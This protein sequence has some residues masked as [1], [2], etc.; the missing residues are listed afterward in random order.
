MPAEIRLSDGT[1]IKTDEQ[2]SADLVLHKLYGHQTFQS[3]HDENGEE[4]RI[5]PAHVVYVR[6]V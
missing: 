4:Y 2:T 3:I 6:D 1:T 5:N